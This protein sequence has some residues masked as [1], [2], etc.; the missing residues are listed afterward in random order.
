M[1]FSVFPC[2]LRPSP[3]ATVFCRR[4]FAL[5][6]FQAPGTRLFPFL[7]PR[8]EKAVTAFPIL[9]Q[10]SEVHFLPLFSFPSWRRGATDLSTVSPPYTPA[11]FRGFLLPT[12]ARPVFRL[13][14]FSLLVPRRSFWVCSLAT[15]FSFLFSP[16]REANAGS[17]FLLLAAAVFWHVPF[18]VYV[19]GITPLLLSSF[20]GLTFS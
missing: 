7:P 2:L 18:S 8:R 15:L 10:T 3:K 11:H 5:F 14:H 13:L 12:R 16:S 20:P 9:A 17:A 19:P 6:P 4:L 1:T